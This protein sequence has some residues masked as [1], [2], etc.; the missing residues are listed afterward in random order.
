MKFKTT[1]TKADPWLEPAAEQP[2]KDAQNI[3]NYQLDK[4]FS[5]V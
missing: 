3:Y 1:Q 2:A 5:G 4:L